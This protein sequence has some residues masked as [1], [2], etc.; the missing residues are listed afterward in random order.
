MWVGSWGSDGSVDGRLEQRGTSPL[1]AATGMEHLQ[2]RAVDVQWRWTVWAT[3]D[4]VDRLDHCWPGPSMST[5]III[6]DVTDLSKWKSD[7]VSSSTSSS[8]ES[9]TPVIN[10]SCCCGCAATWRRAESA[11]IRVP[12]PYSRSNFPSQGSPTPFPV[13]LCLWLS[14]SAL[15]ST[16]VVTL[17]RTRLVLGWVT[18]C[19]RAN[20]LGM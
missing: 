8:R 9:S 2:G 17:R 15:V 19:G 7:V 3:A 1:S 20:R 11:T 18:V 12:T 4:Q 13:Q 14:G 6:L 5:E 16:N 10:A